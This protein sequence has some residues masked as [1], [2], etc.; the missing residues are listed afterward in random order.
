MTGP[1]QAKEY[2]A[3]AS[4]E[5]GKTAGIALVYLLATGLA[6][7]GAIVLIPLYTRKLSV[8]KFGDYAL[9]Q[10]LVLL[11]PTLLSL[12]SVAAVA[13][14]YFDG[15]DLAAARRK[16][17]SAARIAILITFAG[18]LLAQ[19]L[20]FALARSGE[21]LSGRWELTC[22]LWAS[23]GGL[24]SMVPLDYLRASQRPLTASALQLVQF[25]ASVVAG[26]VLVAVMHRGLRGAI[27]ALAVAGV[28]NGAI[29]VAF[30]AVAL[31]GPV[32]RALARESLAF[33]LPFVPHFA[34]LQIG[35]AADRWIMKGVGHEAELGAYALGGQLT[36]PTQMVVQAWNEASAPKM[37]EMTR[38]GGMPLVA[39]KIGRIFATYAGA[40]VA[41][42][43]L[44]VLGL[45]FLRWVVGE[46]FAGALWLVPILLGLVAMEALYLPSVNVLYYAKRTGYI[47]IITSSCALI[48]GV[49]NLV[50]V[51]VIGVW[52]AIASR[53]LS[54]TLR[55]GL[56]YLAARGCL[57]APAPAPVNVDT[58]QP[59]SHDRALGRGA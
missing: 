28:L 35:S 24:C 19:T 53:G 1:Q 32:T 4:R 54:A 36:A 47:P 9:A 55:S 17:G 2:A 16:S 56:I 15:N 42:A 44:T 57:R 27:E 45:P 23:V 33:S 48:N 10:T 40:A 8:E 49:A 38:A 7:A 43:V 3:P 41:P 52:G 5:T 25:A 39:Q 11:L 29:G 26:V 34:A 6:R 46:K 12:G 22:I 51:P 58:P 14:F 31:P 21:R 30:V 59:N 18:A 13:R 20:I 50:L 37:G